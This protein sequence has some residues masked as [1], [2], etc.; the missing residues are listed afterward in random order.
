MKFLYQL[1]DFYLRSSLHVGICL[2]ALFLSQKPYLSTDSAWPILASILFLTVAGYN[3]TKYLL[4]ILKGRDFRFRNYILVLTSI[5]ILGL[6]PFLVY[7]N[8]ESTLVLL[9]II[10][11]G[12]LYILPL[13]AGKSLRHF[14]V[15]KLISVAIVWV[16]IIMVLP[17]YLDEGLLFNGEYKIHLRNAHYEEFYFGLRSLQLFFLVIALCIPFE[18]RD[19]KYD[20]EKLKTLPQMIGVQKSKLIGVGLCLLCIVIEVLFWDHLITKH[21]IINIAA[22]TLTSFLIL[23]S[24]KDKSD[25]Y[26]SFWVEAVPIFWLI[27]LWIF[28]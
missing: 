16:L 26:A 24:N 18:I 3:V 4:P 20:D 5:S 2:T 15:V 8:L 9:G 7:G 27:T 11:I 14:P 22:Y 19:L 25:Y 1:F 12:T 28:R 21:L 6:V 23:G 10:T 17:L 13:F